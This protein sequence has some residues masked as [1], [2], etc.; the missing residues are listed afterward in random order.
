MH[1]DD[2][3]SPFDLELDEADDVTRQFWGATRGWAADERP[4]GGR[5]AQRRSRG[6]DTTGS[7]RVIRDG[8]AAFR[9]SVRSDATA[10][11][12]RTRQHGVTR[13]AAQPEPAREASLGEL[14]AGWFDDDGDDWSIP[15]TPAS[16]PRPRSVDDADL[17]ALT[18]VEPFSTRLGLGA[19]DPL[20]VRLGVVITALVL[21]VPLALSL[22]PN[23]AQA[24]E[25]VP[26]VVAAVGAAPLTTAAASSIDVASSAATAPAAVAIESDG[27]SEAPGAETADGAPAVPAAG[28]AAPDTATAPATG[29]LGDT[30]DVPDSR[31]VSVE[32]ATVDQVAERQ[33]PECPQTYEAAAGDSWYRIADAA[34][35]TPAALLSENRA[36]VDS[37]I[38]PGDGICLP[39]GAAMPA[40]PA[41]TEAPSTADAPSTTEAPTTTPVPTTIAPAAPASA[42]RDEVQQII[43]DVFP[44]ELEE[45]ALEIALRESRYRAT[46]YNG[47]CCYGVFQIYWSV[48]QSWLDDYGVNSATDLFDA[49]KNV[50]AA[51]ALYRGSG[52]WSP[53]GG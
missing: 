20:L 19:V 32:A 29:Q 3:N 47:W 8:F 27:P 44:D 31:T 13:V 5:P 28:D 16:S 52:G 1:R 2:S 6:G 21:L 38:L 14:A 24:T 15:P 49:R 17:I 33:I 43:R 18:P 26:G 36:T 42:S 4:T 39:A 25:S 35:V 51:Y 53:W 7:L 10:E 11:T 40:A 50:E 34:G 48:H 9:P 41:P 30:G 45:R 46:A 23:D 12:G 22:R 37:V